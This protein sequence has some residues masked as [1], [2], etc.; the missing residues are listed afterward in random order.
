MSSRSGFDL[1]TNSRAETG[2]DLS[3]S[4]KTSA[5]VEASKQADSKLG[6]GTADKAGKA[7]NVYDSWSAPP[8]AERY[9]G[10]YWN[11]SSILAGDAGFEKLKKMLDEAAATSEAVRSEREDDLRKRS[12]AAGALVAAYV[13]IGTIAAAALYA[14]TEGAI[15]LGNFLNSNHDSQEE[16][17]RADRAVK[18]LWGDWMISPPVLI[19]ELDSA[20]SYADR[21]E[22]IL[23]VF[24]ASEDSGEPWQ[25]EWLATM[26]AGIQSPMPAARDVS[27]VGWIPVDGTSW[28]GIGY[29]GSAFKSP[30]EDKGFGSVTTITH[31]SGFLSASRD[32][33]D[34]YT[35]PTYDE[36]AA[37]MD[38]F[39]AGV[40]VMVATRR[41]VAIEPVVEAAVAASRQ[42]LQELGPDGKLAGFRLK[43][44][45]Q[46]AEKAALTAPKNPML[47]MRATVDSRLDRMTQTVKAQ[48]AEMLKGLILAPETVRM[49][50]AADKKLSLEDRGFRRFREWRAIGKAPKVVLTKDKK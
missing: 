2:F 22:N 42:W 40:G 36:M 18:K 14:F 16:R 44:V 50:V 9:S 33:E 17:D 23:R 29:Y 26:I 31:K 28:L 25:K 21:V 39:A 46:E 37:R 11:P 3:T 20:R 43:G 10:N 1:L 5:K 4:L 12:A 47:V 34:K 30:Y 48:K 15:A 45:F 35:V 6:E 19:P 24:Q 27:R 13:P 7:K 38:P 32:T 8:V 49:L 41:A